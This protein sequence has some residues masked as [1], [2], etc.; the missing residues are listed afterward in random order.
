MA[1]AGDPRAG[2]RA[3]LLGA[4]AGLH[5]ARRQPAAPARASSRA[6]AWRTTGPAGSARTSAPTPA[7]RRTG[8]RSRAPRGPTSPPSSACSPTPTTRAGTV[9]EARWPAPS[10]SPRRTTTRAPATRCGAI[11]DPSAWRRWSRRWPS[12]ELLIADGHHRYE[13]ARVYAE[14]VGG[15][16]EHRYVLMF[17]CSLSDPGLLGLPHPP[18]AHRP[19]GRPRQAGGHPRDADARLRRRGRSP[20]DELEPAGEPNGRVQLGYMDSF[21]KQPY[22]LTLKDQSIADAALAG[23]ARALPAP[24]HR[25]ARGDRPQGR[26][27]HDRGRHLPPARPGLL[28][29]LRRRP[30]RGGVRPRRRRLLHARHARSSRCARWPRR[31]SRCRR[32]RPTSIP[33]SR[34]AWSSTSSSSR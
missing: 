14:E 10:R 2:V 1:P 23:Q 34:P 4:A 8:W 21:H 29:E 26:A 5:R 32:S 9:L 19:E 3:R 22:L 28:Q 25:G 11:G 27:R 13:T 6:C 15:E 24:G 33:R 30:R 16:G 7:P 17:L 20:R 18:A 12:A 31:A